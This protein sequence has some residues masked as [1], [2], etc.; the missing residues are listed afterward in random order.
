MTMKKRKNHQL[1][2]EENSTGKLITKNPQKLIYTGKHV[3]IEVLGTLPMDLSN[4]KVTIC[5]FNLA[6]LN[7][8]RAKL[9]LFDS[10]N[11][12]I[13]LN[14]L[15]EKENINVDFL[16]DDFKELTTRLEVHREAIYEKEALFLK[17]C[18]KNEMTGKIKNLAFNLLKEQDLPEKITRLL[19][20]CGI[21]GEENA[22]FALFVI[23][24]SY[25]TNYHI[26]SIVQ[27]E[28]GSG[29]SHLINTVAECIP[30]EDVLNFT[31]IT[32]KAL[33]YFE[34]DDLNNKLILIQD[35]ESL[36][37]N[38]K[39]AFR[40]LQSSGNLTSSFA[41]KDKTGT[42]NA[43]IKQVSAQFSSIITTSRTE[44]F[45]DNLS[46]SVIIGVDESYDQTDRIIKY[47]NDSFS[48]EF[49]PGESDSIKCLLRN[50]VR[51][52]KSYD[53]INP[54]ANRLI[55]PSGIKMARRLNHQFN[56]FVANITILNQFMRK[57]DSKSRLITTKE[58]LL[59][60]VNSFFNCIFLKVDDLD[61]STRQFFE[62]LKAYIIKNK[63]TGYLFTQREVRCYLNLSKTMVNRYLSVLINHEYIYIVSGPSNKG[64]KYKIAVW[65]DTEKFKNKLKK[66]LYRQIKKL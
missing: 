26:H 17:T 60:A 14:N 66:D 23:A 12:E 35:F 61:S 15:A 50:C 32:G 40:E 52:L 45:Y 36:D 22:R 39:L 16:W 25:K 4:M 63:L 44:I 3:T 42:L 5:V 51:N 43:K 34:S 1:T 62:K 57:K 20:N 64:F 29:K 47:Q 49:D 41:I 55:L 33:Y 21:I 8:T 9:D 18:R 37:F 46:R 11:I 31:R 54:F 7:K 2:G 56:C 28:S 6:S 59:T 30:Q 65:D 24:L 10:S 38:A 58:D 19:G 53:V 13:F 48:G 27:G